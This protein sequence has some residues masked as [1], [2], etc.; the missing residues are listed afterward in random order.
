MPTFNSRQ[1]STLGARNKVTIGVIIVI[2]ILIW[3]SF[4]TIGPGDRG[5]LMTFGAVHQGVLAPGLHVRI[6][7][8]QSVKS[9]N[10]QIQ[11][12]QTDE[13]AA[14][15][16]LQEVTTTVA[17]NWSINPTDAEWV[18]QNIGAESVIP[19]KIIAPIVSNAVKAVAAHYNA[20]Q[21][22]EKRDTVRSQID[23]QIVTALAGYRIQV[24]GV[25]ITNFA[26]SP[27]YSAAIE[28]KQVAQ[29]KALQ[30]QYVL[31]QVQVEA[32]QAIAKAKGQAE[33]Q[34]LVQSTL[35]PEIIQLKAVDRWNGIL[36]QVVGSKGVL[37]MI[38][39]VSA[40][41]QNAPPEN[42]KGGP[43]RAPAVSAR[44]P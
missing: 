28:R 24:E 4:V 21:L 18:Y 30:A 41:A 37:P 26:F 17:V 39:N 22:I 38:G 43:A 13:S 27:S 9:M 6:P 11:K 32:Q 29:Q 12:S 42:S 10:V 7:F 19:G 33:A 35:T 3:S 20:E 2:L 14:S 15:L 23:Q 25:N 5:V 1:F 16:D 31:K 34:K 36:P 8:M 44:Q 40:G